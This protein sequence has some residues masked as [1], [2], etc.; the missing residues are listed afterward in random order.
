[1]RQD[2]DGT[3]TPHHFVLGQENGSH[4]ASAQRPQQTVGAEEE[5]LVFAL[6]HLVGLPPA[7]NAHVHQRVGDGAGVG[8]IDTPILQVLPQLRKAV[9]GNEAASLDPIQKRGGKLDRHWIIRSDF[10][11]RKR[12]AYKIIAQ[13]ARASEYHPTPLFSNPA[14]F[15]ASRFPP[16]CPDFPSRLSQ[17]REKVRKTRAKKAPCIARA[18]D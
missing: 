12:N 1:M 14:A 10:R 7:Q 9:F 17:V 18:S 3:L 4:P 11:A 5:P 8:Q 6:E 2:F 13:P 16:Q 15:S